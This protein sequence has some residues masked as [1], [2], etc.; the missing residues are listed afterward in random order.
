MGNKLTNGKLEI[1]KNSPKYWEFIRTVRNHPETKKG[2]IQQKHIT[3]EEHLEYM[4][5]H[6]ERYFICLYESKPAGF[7][8]SVNSDIRVATHP[9]YLRKGIAKKLIEHI[10]SVYP[11]S[12]AKIKIK[13]NASLRLFES[14]GFVKKFYLLEHKK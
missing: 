8:G 3:K 10:V 4:Q 6:G 11:D 14:C 12:L 13:N 9:S 1:V 2:F 5:K 7:V